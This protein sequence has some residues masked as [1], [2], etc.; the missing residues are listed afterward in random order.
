[1]LPADMVAH[2]EFIAGAIR[3]LLFH[4]YVPERDEHLVDAAMEDWIKILE[5]FSEKNIREARDRWLDTMTRR[6]SPAE[7]KKICF[8]IIYEIRFQE[9]LRSE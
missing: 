2:S 5:P 1:M 7:I 6:P 8:E 3:S 9:K 4:F